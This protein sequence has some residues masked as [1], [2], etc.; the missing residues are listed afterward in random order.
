MKKIHFYLRNGATAKKTIY[1]ELK[2][3]K[4]G[5]FRQSLGFQVQPSDWNKEKMRV[6]DKAGILDR[7]LINNYL[8]DLENA[9]QHFFYEC[10]AKGIKISFDKVKTFL[11]DYQHPKDTTESNFLDYLNDYI[12]EVKTRKSITT[13]KALTY[14]TIHKFTEFRDDIK[15]YCKQNNKVL[16]FN[17]ID[18][19]FY[20][21][22]I[23]YLESKGLALNTIGRYIKTLKTILNSAETK[24]IQINK[25]CNSMRFKAPKENVSNIYLTAEELERIS[26]ISLSKDLDNARKLFLI[27]AFTG[28]RYS[29]FSRITT[30]N[31][32]DNNKYIRIIQQKTGNEVVIPL[33]PY[34]KENILPYLAEIKPITNQVLNRDIKRICQLAEIQDKVIKE[35]TKGGQKISQTFEKWQLVGTHTAR[36]SFATNSYLNGVP[37]ITIMKITGH[38]TEKAFLSYI[39]I[40][41]EQNADIMAKY[42][43]EQ[44][45]TKVIL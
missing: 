35:T 9:L 15:E 2:E 39:K 8:N 12:K 13:G 26:S 5:K 33:H 42:W 17:D 22:F 43:K 31:I 20:D 37:A 1:L 11:F 27:G 29:D 25:V 40:S 19:S 16:S 24:G 28:L 32:T 36:R 45:E 23:N 18:L 34:I 21:S 38:K 4:N 3:G 30:D 14:G 44:E 41:N 6:R 7:V 10:T